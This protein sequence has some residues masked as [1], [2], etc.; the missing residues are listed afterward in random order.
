MKKNSREIVNLL[1]ELIQ[2]IFN[3]FQVIKESTFPWNP[4]EALRN[5]F[6]AAEKAFLDLAQA[7]EDHIDRSGSCAIAILIV[8]DTCY[9]ANVGDSRAVLSGDYGQKVYTL[10]RDHKP[11][12]ELEQKRIIN[13]GGKIYQ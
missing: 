8:G 11:G 5:G 4:K 12:D 13:G 3:N 1:L 2:F 6:I 7:S 10:S 9:V